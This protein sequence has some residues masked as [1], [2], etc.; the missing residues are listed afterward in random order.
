MTRVA[1]TGGPRTGKTTLALGLEVEIVSG[2]HV[3][4]SKAT[5]GIRTNAMARA[6]G[7]AERK[8]VEQGTS[9]P[10]S[11][12]RPPRAAFNRDETTQA[13]QVKRMTDAP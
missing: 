9:S 12:T 11:N 3:K 8:R 1:I 4:S 2:G 10:A 13:H 7:R 6:R 5:L